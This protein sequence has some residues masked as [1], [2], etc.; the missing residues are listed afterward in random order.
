MRK[1]IIAPV[2]L[3]LL[4]VAG[5]GETQGQR[6]ATGA[7]GG[8]IAGAVVGGPV[9]ALAGA[10]IGAAGAVTGIEAGREQ[11]P[12][13]VERPGQGVRL[14][15]LGMHREDIDRRWVIDLGG[16]ESRLQRQNGYQGQPWNGLGPAHGGA[17]SC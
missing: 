10:G 15:D 14:A 6:A 4:G 1:W 17:I 9:G 8:A 12:A 11:P 5:C 2:G 16:G 3:A 13:V 7:G